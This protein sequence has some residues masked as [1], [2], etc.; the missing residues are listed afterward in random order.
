MFKFLFGVSVIMLFLSSGI[1][2]QTK[3]SASNNPY[4]VP[5]PAVATPKAAVSEPAAAKEEPK[6]DVAEEDDNA[7]TDAA[8]E[9]KY[10][11]LKKGIHKMILSLEKRILNGLSNP[12]GT[13]S[14]VALINGSINVIEVHKSL[15]SI[16][17]P[18]IKNKKTGDIA[19]KVN[20]TKDTGSI[21][22]EAK[23][24]V[25][26]GCS[27]LIFT[28]D[29]GKGVINVKTNPDYLGGYT[30]ADDKKPAETEKP[31]ATGKSGKTKAKKGK[32]VPPKPAAK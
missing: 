10:K 4:I 8:T 11:D 19:Y 7:I 21:K 15:D 14:S 32:A 25:I 28:P 3:D 22:F 23:T 16:L 30:A 6:A 31:A 5:T 1:Y 9:N 18:T 29:S 2:A 13:I 26:G 24:F 27:E 12:K 20:V 17:K